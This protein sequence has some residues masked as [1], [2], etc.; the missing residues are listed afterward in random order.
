MQV[1]GLSNNSWLQQLQQD[2]L[3]LSAAGGS[4]GQS[5]PVGG[6][7]STGDDAANAPAGPPPVAG[8]SLLSSFMLGALFGAQAQTQAQSSGSTD[9]ASSS[10]ADVQPASTGAGTPG[11][12]LLASNVLSNLFDAQQQQPP[13]P[14]SFMAGQILK[15]DDTNGDGQLS[16]QEITN[17]LTPANGTAPDATSLQTAFNQL[18]SNGDGELSASELAAGIGKMTQTHSTGHHHHHHGGVGGSQFMQPDSASSSSSTTASSA[19]S[20]ATNSGDES[21]STASDTTA[22]TAS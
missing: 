18:D 14:G 11:G 9:A 6:Q 15:A 17:A 4:G 5:L 3:G 13:A 8:G 1:A 20:D 12:G 16:L 7:A 22:S 2:L 21:A 10:D 19:T